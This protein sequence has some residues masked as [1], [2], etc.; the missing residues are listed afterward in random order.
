MENF[1]LDLCITHFI[2]RKEV[3][4]GFQIRDNVSVIFAL[5]KGGQYI[6]LKNFKIY[7]ISWIMKK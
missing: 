4:I 1:K 2:T 5:L 6:F 3:S 7:K